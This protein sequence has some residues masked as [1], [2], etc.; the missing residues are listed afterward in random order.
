MISWSS[1]GDTRNTDAFLDSMLRDVPYSQLEPL[2]QRGVEALKAATPRDSGATADGWDYEIDNK[3]AGVAIWWTNSN[4][5]NGFNV[6]IGLKYG[7][8][9]GTGGWV[10]GYDFISPVIKPIFDQIADQVWKEVQKA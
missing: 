1:A 3:G 8:A 9:T 2:A 5:I 6:V 10:E 4:E 7:H